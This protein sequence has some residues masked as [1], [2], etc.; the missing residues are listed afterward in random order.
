M[1]VYSTAIT[2]NGYIS[3]VLLSLMS[4]KDMHFEVPPKTFRL[5]GWI[6]QQI[7][8]RVPNCRTGD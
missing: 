3:N 4:G 7:R 1:T 6:T 8:E 2:Q 5:H